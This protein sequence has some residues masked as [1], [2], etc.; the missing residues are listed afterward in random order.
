MNYSKEQLNKLVEDLKRQ[1]DELKVKLHLAK[2]DAKDEWIKLEMKYEEVKAKIGSFKKEAG[3]SAE[4]VSATLGLAA[5]EIK[6][7]YERLRKMM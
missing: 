3:K 1:R 7:E 2:A 4:T 6:K 5:D